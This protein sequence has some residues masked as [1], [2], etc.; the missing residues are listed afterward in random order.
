[1]A[2]KQ[3]KKET[4]QDTIPL[5]AALT[6]DWHFMHNAW[7]HRPEIC[8]DAAASLEQV[9]DYVRYYKLPI[10]AA[11]DL[12]DNT[13][14]T[15]SVISSLWDTLGNRGISGF[16]INGN[17]DKV[18]PSWLT[19]LD[20]IFLH[21]YT[22]RAGW[23]DLTEIPPPEVPGCPDEWK[24]FPSQ[25][26][27]IKHVPQNAAEKWTQEL[28]A[29]T[30]PTTKWCAY[31]ID[32]VETADQLQEKLNELEPHL[33]K[34]TKNLLVLHQGVE[35]LIPKMKAELS[36]GMIP[37]GVDIVLCG[38]T[39]I[40]KVLFVET[41]GG[42]SI[43]L[44]SPGSLH[45]CSIDEDPRKKCY[46]LGADGSVWSVPVFT[47]RV[48]TVNFSGCAESEI[49]E[50]AIK[51]VASLKKKDDSKKAEIRKKL[52][53]PLLRVVYDTSTAPKIRSIF[54]TALREAEVE[55][56]LFYKNNAEKVS[57][58]LDSVAQDGI[59]TSFV[60]SGFDYAKAAFQKL[61]KDK[62]VRRI[63]E[64]M[65]ESQPSQ[66]SYDTLKQEFVKK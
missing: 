51:V 50:T 29:W 9:L 20:G 57:N 36:D 16:H 17:H 6:S 27:G 66:E 25:T 49:R 5:I 40:S 14:P 43:P 35:G 21:E 4:P 12:L 54:E 60:N 42:K 46:F 52:G 2:K 30:P 61:E 8:G 39:H 41:K 13:R 62:K 64:A 65:L 37:D 10:I 56:H 63:V 58:D 24:V 28:Q 19:A 26:D 48:I 38:H 11:G 15:S 44:V 47:R 59:D 7:R 31:G 18:K 34:D 33:R 22:G 45:M 23:I 32:Y 3:P 55:A 53:A 1:M